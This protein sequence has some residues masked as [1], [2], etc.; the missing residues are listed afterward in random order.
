MKTSARSKTRQDILDAAY[1]LILEEGVSRLT[2]NAVAAKA[3]V[4]KGGLLYHFPSKEALITGMIQDLFGQFNQQMRHETNEDEHSPGKWTRAYV[5]TTFLSGEREE[6]ELRISAG[7]LA[8]LENRSELLQPAQAFYQ[9]WQEKMET[10][11]IDP[12]I[13]TV[14]RLA[15]DGL[16]FSEMFGLA[17][18]LDMDMRERV[19]NI[20]LRLSNGEVK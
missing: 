2:L 10:D 14:C 11:G 19:I 18:L 16:W 9:D 7:L 3:S 6:K 8:A 17:P 5:K 12:A 4:S 15:A 20:L 1:A 13:A